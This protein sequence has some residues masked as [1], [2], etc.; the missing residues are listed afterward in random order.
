MTRQLSSILT[1]SRRPFCQADLCGTHR[2]CS[3]CSQRNRCARSHRGRCVTLPLAACCFAWVIMFYPHSVLG[4]NPPPNIQYTNKAADLG[5]RGNAKVNSSTLGLE[6]EIPLGSY[7]GRAGLNLPVIL[8]YSSK[9]HRLSYEGYNPGH[10]SSSGQ[11]IGDGYAIVIAKYGE[12]SAS[13][14]TSSLGAPQLDFTLT[15]QIYDNS[16]RPGSNDGSACPLCIYSIDRMLVWMPDGSSHE[17]RSSDRPR[18]GS[19]PL[20]DDLYAVD[21]SRLRYQRSTGTLFLPDGTR[22]ANGQYIDRNGNV[23]TG[24]NNQW[25]DTV[26]RVIGNPFATPGTTPSAG[27]YVYSL[28][29]VGTS[30]INYTFKWRNLGDAGV[31]TTPEPLRY[32]ANQGCPFGAGSYSPSLFAAQA[33]AYICNGGNVFNPVVLYQIVLPTGQ[34]YTFTY[35]IYGEID[36]VIFPTGGYERY[37]HGQIWPVSFMSSPY[38]Q[39]NRG[40]GSRWVSA[41]G[42]STDEVQWQYFKP[43]GGQVNITA[44]DNS[45]TQLYLSTENLSPSFGYTPDGARVGMTYEERFYSPPDGSGNRQILRRNLTDWTMTGSNGGSLA[46]GANR[47][48]R[49]TKQVELLLDTGGSALA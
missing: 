17:L 33:D 5:L 41:T 44:P 13:G 38:N 14:W 15:N 28:P 8:N 47:N 24:V 27:D 22:Y 1:K 39:G 46:Q 45:L 48:A 29:G 35:N 20:P 25:T 23:L 43:T 21:G 18:V 32:V 34:A 37:A 3:N 26:G 40:V 2:P 30:T 9:V 11:P 12:H 49:V 31:Q 36:K 6:L 10:F 19:D 16:G 7:P 42:L 4:Q